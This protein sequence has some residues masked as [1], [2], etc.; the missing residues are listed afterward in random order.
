MGRAYALELRE[1]AVAAVIAAG[2]SQAEVTTFF[3]VA[4]ATLKRWLTLWRTGQSL[5]AKRG[6]PGPAGFFESAAAQETLR[7][8]VAAAPDERL[9][10][11]CRRW[12]KAT[13][14]R[15]SR[16]TMGRAIARMGWTRKKSI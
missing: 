1:R 13:G 11:H 6:K 2:Q 14:K 12:R 10:D 4:L 9:D 7:A 16:A 5:E 3:D 15:V 8:Q